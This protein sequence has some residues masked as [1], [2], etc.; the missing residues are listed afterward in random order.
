MGKESDV[1]MGEGE[2]SYHF[3]YVFMHSKGTDALESFYKTCGLQVFVSVFAFSDIS[4]MPKTVFQKLMDSQVELRRAQIEISDMK[5]E[6]HKVRG[7]FGE[8]MLTTMEHY[9]ALEEENYELRK[10]AECCLRPETEDNCCA[11]DKGCC[12]PL[13]PRPKFYM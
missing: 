2:P 13:P 6:L 3:D 9:E 12:M 4:Q 10:A 11:T 1:D 8:Y 5:N 7:A